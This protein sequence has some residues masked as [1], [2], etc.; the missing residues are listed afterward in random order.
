MPS[1]RAR[2]NHN[3]EQLTLVGPT[4]EDSS[5]WIA[6]RSSGGVVYLSA[7]TIAAAL[8]T[9][10]AYTPVTADIPTAPAEQPA[11]APAAA[12]AVAPAAEPERPRCPACSRP[13]T[14]ALGTDHRCDVIKQVSCLVCRAADVSQ[15]ADPPL[16]GLVCAPCKTQGHFLCKHCGRAKPRSRMVDVCDSCNPLQPSDIWTQGVRAIGD[17]IMV[18]TRCR[19]PFAVEVES[20]RDP[21][22][23]E[24]EGRVSGLV[25][26]GRGSDGS[27]QPDQGCSTP[28]EWRS[29]PFRGDGGLRQL[30]TDIEVIRKGGF[31]AN[32]SCGLHVHVDMSETT[33]EEREALHKFGKWIQN[34]IFKLVASSRADNHYCKKLGNYATDKTDKYRWLSIQSFQRH[35]TVEFRLHH[36]ITQPEIV[37]EWV[38]VC[39]RIVDRGLKLGMLPNQPSE[40]LFTLLGFNEYEKRFWSAR[41]KKLHG[42]NVEV[43]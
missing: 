23:A 25:G 6:E 7:E 27:I 10:P 31:R 41:A 34:D 22:R 42:R 19:R 33:D 5:V 17:D 29:P 13:Y 2:L 9:V 18:L 26:W 1:E 8:G 16:A 11:E 28:T 43:V 38:K 15:M 24:T 12:P 40:S 14:G 39:L 21:T 36:G 20:F 35:R 32:D 3:G 4:V 37:A 30:A